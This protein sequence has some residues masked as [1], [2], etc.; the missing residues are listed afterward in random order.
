MMACQWMNIFLRL[1]I[2]D[3]YDDIFTTWILQRAWNDTS[4]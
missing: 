4:E 1:M 2:Y 3:D